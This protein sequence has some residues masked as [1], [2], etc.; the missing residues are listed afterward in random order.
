MGAVWSVCSAGAVGGVP[1]G[2]VGA[3][4]GGVAVGDV[5]AVGEVG[6]A[7][8]STPPSSNTDLTGEASFA[9]TKVGDASLGTGASLFS[10]AVTSS[11]IATHFSGV[12]SAEMATLLIAS[13]FGLSACTLEGVALEGVPPSGL[14]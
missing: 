4:V 5:G 12:T 6:D 10:S 2:D 11:P 8:A 14:P 7:A 3:A 13:V 9:Y 1:V